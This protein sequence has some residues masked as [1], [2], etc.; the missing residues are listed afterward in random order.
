MAAAAIS[1]ERSRN[2][3]FIGTPL[4]LGS[5][6]PSIWAGNTYRLNGTWK[7]G[8]SLNMRPQGTFNQGAGLR[9]A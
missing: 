8:E 2:R 7:T 3:S 9:L 1:H 4:L 5:P 6:D